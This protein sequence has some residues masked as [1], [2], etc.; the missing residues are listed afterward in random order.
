[1]DVPLL[2]Q[3]RVLTAGLVVYLVAFLFIFKT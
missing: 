1:M 2:T 3:P